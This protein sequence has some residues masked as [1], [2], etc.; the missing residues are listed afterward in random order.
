MAD[1][2]A[3]E[4][5]NGAENNAPNNPTTST[6]LEMRPA[7]KLVNPP[8][9]S[10]LGEIVEWSVLDTEKA[11]GAI[12]LVLEDNLGDQQSVVV[13]KNYADKVKFKQ[14]FKIGDIARVVVEHRKENKT[15]YERDGEFFYHNT[16]SDSVSSL[17]RSSKS[18]FLRS[19]GH[20]NIV[21]A[22]PE[23]KTPLANYFG[24]MDSATL[25]ME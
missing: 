12:L 19:R 23:D 17:A 15:T 16:T 1:T 20:M 25:K 13:G 24:Q 2:K 4:K 21:D 5:D 10:L 18:S 14:R 6:G 7:D 3:K 8:T 22:S 9:S 11:N